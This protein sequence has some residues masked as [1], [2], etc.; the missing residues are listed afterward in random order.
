MMQNIVRNKG[1]LHNRITR[2]IRLLPFNLNETER[3]LQWKGQHSA[4]PK[5]APTSPHWAAVQN[6]L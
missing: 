1:G 3:F 2:R 6:A 4:K 5:F